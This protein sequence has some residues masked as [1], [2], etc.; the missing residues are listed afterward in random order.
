MNQCT[1]NTCVLHFFKQI[2]GK[3]FRPG[4]LPQIL[5]NFVNILT[6]TLIYILEQNKGVRT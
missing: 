3:L 6:E 2:A 4:E 1:C 5:F